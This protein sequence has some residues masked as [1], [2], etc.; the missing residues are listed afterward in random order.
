MTQKITVDQQLSAEEGTSNMS[1]LKI[2]Y[3]PED[4]GTVRIS[5]NAVFGMDVEKFL[6]S[7][8]EEPIFDL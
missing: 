1:E 6:D 5:D 3:K 7:L 2:I 8:P 4:I